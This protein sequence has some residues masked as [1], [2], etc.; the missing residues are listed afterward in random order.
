MT[1]AEIGWNRRQIAADRRLN[2]K[3]LINNQCDCFCCWAANSEQHGAARLV[4]EFQVQIVGPDGNVAAVEKATGKRNSSGK[5][6]SGDGG[7]GGAVAVLFVCLSRPFENH[8]TEVA[9]LCAQTNEFGAQFVRID[10]QF[11]K[12]FAGQSVFD[13]LSR[14]GS[15]SQVNKFPIFGISRKINQS[16]NQSMVQLNKCNQLVGMAGCFSLGRRRFSNGTRLNRTLRR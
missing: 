9:L 3:S 16:I 15:G 8:R 6:A 14:P 1:T 7:G 4:D 5:L 12:Q 2:G 10:Q 13:R 11:A